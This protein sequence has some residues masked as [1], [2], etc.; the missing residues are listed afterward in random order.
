VH[1]QLLF[2]WATDIHLDMLNVPQKERFYRQVAEARLD[3]LI[4]TGDISS[5]DDV[6][7]HLCELVGE[8]KLPLVA[9]VLGNH[10]YYGGRI[11]RVREEIKLI[12]DAHPNLVY[13]PERALD[14]GGG[15]GRTY[16]IGVDGWSDARTPCFAS[17]SIQLLDYFEIADLAAVNRWSHAALGAELER[18]GRAEAVILEARLAEVPASCKRLLIAT[19]PP[20]FRGACWHEGAVSNDQWAPHFTCVSTGE[21]IE[22][23]AKAHPDVLV[24]TLCG[25]T[26]GG[27]VYCPEGVPNLAVH[28]GAACYGSPALQTLTFD[29]IRD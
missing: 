3:G 2:G 13:L 20:P 24:T 8:A 15:A 25:H 11:E 14:I 9:F 1:K 17:S 23:W 10:D 21:V 22:A 28:T 7:P 26:H 18:L 4:V 12:V 5:G 29:I 6:G 27:G 16:L 19:H